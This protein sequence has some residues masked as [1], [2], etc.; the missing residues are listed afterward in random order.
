MDVDGMMIL[1]WFL[2]EKY[3]KAWTVLKL[4]RMGSAFGF[5]ECFVGCSWNFWGG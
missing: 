4:F 3:V 1:K 2:S 5:W